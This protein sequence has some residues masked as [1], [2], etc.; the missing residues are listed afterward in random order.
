VTDASGHATFTF[1]DTT[2]PGDDVVVASFVDSNKITE[3]SNQAVEHWIAIPTTLTYTGDTT[4]D[5]NDQA[6]L[7]ARLTDS[8]N[9]AVPGQSISFTIGAESCSAVTDATGTASCPVTLGDVPNTYP[10]KA[11][12]AGKSQYLPSNASASFT[13]TLEESALVSTDKLQLFAAN[14]TATLS[15]VLT[16]PNGG[17]PIGGK[18]VSMTLGSGSSAQ[19]CTGTTDASGTATCSINP[20]TVPLGP[21]PVAD[22]FAGDTYYKPAS[23]AQYA[24]VYANLASG[25]FVI[26]D[27]TVAAASPT[28][29]VNWWGSKWWKN[30]SL[31]GGT[32]PAAFKGFADTL[33]TKPAAC[34]GSWTT[35]P[36]NSSGP[37]SSVPSYMSVIVSSTI[38]K[39]GSTISGDVPE[40]VIVKTDGGYA[41]NPGHPGTGTIVATLCHS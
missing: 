32:A 13:V 6:T 40:I 11:T 18:P 41:A 14:G 10:V 19:S 26:G 23:H 33:S 4:Q 38:A 22:S 36:G 12:Y 31:S 27:A 20:V 1:T 16:D 8:T 25:S 15:S 35:D 2:T 28:T 17:A 39:S 37:P 5:Y 7:S 24:L 30:N 29:S 21:Q 3:S 9:T 34:G